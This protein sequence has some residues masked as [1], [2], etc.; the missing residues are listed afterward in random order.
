MSFLEC[1]LWTENILFAYHK[2]LEALWEHRKAVST[3]RSQYLPWL[4][5]HQDSMTQLCFLVPSLGN[6]LRNRLSYQLLRMLGGECLPQVRAV[7]F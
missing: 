5:T 2:G 7:Q 1:T 6:A 4:G 3:H